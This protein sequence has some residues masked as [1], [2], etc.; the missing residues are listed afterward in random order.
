M[1]E[2]TDA[3]SGLVVRGL[4]VRCGGALAVDGLDLEVPRRRITGLIG[5]NGAGK[6][7][8]FN[9]CTGLTPPSAGMVILDC[10]DITVASPQQRARLGLGRTF[11][12][13]KLFE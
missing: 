12:R 1:A 3:C 5:P 4:T 7:T 10:V 2:P 13:M 8:T 6:T 9:A 11:Q